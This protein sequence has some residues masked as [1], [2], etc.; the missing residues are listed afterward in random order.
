MFDLYALSIC[1]IAL[2]YKLLE[3]Q[4]CLLLLSIYYN[5][6]NNIAQ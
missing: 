4:L 1:G 2:Y 6:V 5:T 3:V